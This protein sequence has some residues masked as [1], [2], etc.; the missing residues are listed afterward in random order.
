MT[1]IR[2]PNSLKES[3]KFANTEILTPSNYR[4][5]FSAESKGVINTKPAIIEKPTLFQ[6]SLIHSRANNYTITFKPINPLPADG[7]IKLVLP[8]H[9]GLKDGAATKCFV[10]TNKLFNTA[11]T[12]EKLDPADTQFRVVRITDV[13]TNAAPY[14]DDI[15]IMLM[16]VNN[17][18]NN[19]AR[20]HPGF[21]LYTYADKDGLWLQDQ[22]E[23]VMPPILACDWPCRECVA[24]D[25]T[26]C[27]ACWQNDPASPVNPLYDLTYL[28]PY[29]GA[30]G[31]CKNECDV[32]YTSNGDTA[33]RRCVQCDESCD[34]CLDEGKVD[35]TKA[36]IKCSAT[37]KYRLM[38]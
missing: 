25:R 13:F 20:S 32:Q 26:D 14:F 12:F 6:D 27:T 1:N 22:A 29:I 36:C 5:S 7:S 23:N 9:I 11:C 3:S 38:D 10:T 28:M 17:P 15:T 4:V 16:H 33:E 2:N 34:D 31:Q 21:N 18:K 30:K 19:R 8:D 37:H 35:D 24:G